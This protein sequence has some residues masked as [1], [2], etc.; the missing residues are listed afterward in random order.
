MTPNFVRVHGFDV[1]PAEGLV[2]GVR[3][4]PV[5]SKDNRGY[6]RVEDRYRSGTRWLA[7]VLVWEAVNGPVLP[8]LEINHK[9]GRKTDN[10][11]S[12]LEMV[13]HQKNI[14]HAYA[15]GLKSNQ[16]DRHPC[17][18]LS[19]SDVRLI[20]QLLS[21]GQTGASIARHYGVTPEA[22][23]AIRSRKNWAHVG[24]ENGN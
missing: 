8:G 11:I 7:H 19:S 16:G 2:Y 13:T 22:I 21:N 4:R 5:G 23:Y 20:R 9:N 10:R 12:N 1:D 24:D 6:I 14:L 3:G 17:R 15:T 18:K